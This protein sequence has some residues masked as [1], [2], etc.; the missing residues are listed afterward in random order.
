MMDAIFFDL[1]GTLTDPKPGITRSIRYALQKLDHPAIPSEDELTWCIGPPLRASFVRLLGAET[2]ADHAV[3]LYRERFSDVGLFENAI[4][5]GIDDVLTALGNS[6]HRLFVATSKPH[7]FADRIIDHFGLRHHFERVFGPGEHFGERVL[8]R[9]LL[10]TG[11][12]V[13]L[14]DSIVLWISQRDFTR[15]ARAFPFME[16]YFK[17][18]I[19]K[20]FGPDMVFAPGSI[21]RSHELESTH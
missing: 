10:R 2:S 8:I 3:S 20:T 12:V 19:E 1:D 7:V 13:A 14:E 9:S 21:E 15:L 4:Y 11:L 17:N 18:Y 5:D 16:A 6:G